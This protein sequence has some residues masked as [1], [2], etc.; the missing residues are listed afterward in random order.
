MRIRK[1]G[2]HKRIFNH[3]KERYS[4]DIEILCNKQKGKELMAIIVNVV[5]KYHD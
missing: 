5:N 1:I 4:L 3:D 2:L